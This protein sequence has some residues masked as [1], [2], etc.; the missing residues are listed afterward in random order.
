MAYEAKTRPERE[1][2]SL[3]ELDQLPE[4]YLEAEYPDIYRARRDRGYRWR[5]YGPWY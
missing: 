5:D 1:I 3:Q 2:V 4:E